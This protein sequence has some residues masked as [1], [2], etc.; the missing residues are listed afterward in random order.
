MGQF[1]KGTIDSATGQTYGNIEVIVVDDGSTDDTAQI[2][3]ESARLDDRVTVIKIGE[4]KG[5]VQARKHGA[6][7]ATGDFV[8]FLDGDDELEPG[9]CETIADAL[10]DGLPDVLQFNIEVI[11][12]CE[13]AQIN[14]K[15]IEAWLR[16]YSE[17]DVV[18]DNLV[19]VCFFEKLFSYNLAGKAFRAGILKEAFSQT[20]EKHIVMAE[21]AYLQFIILHHARSYRGIQ[22]TLYKYYRGRGVTGSAQM[23]VDEFNT[24]CTQSVAIQSIRDFLDGSGL[25]SV[26]A[27]SYN[28]IKEKLLIA[29]INRWR[30]L[31]ATD[32]PA[33]F[34]AMVGSWGREDVSLALDK[35]YD[36]ETAYTEMHQ[37]GFWRY[38]QEKGFRYWAKLY[39]SRPVQAALKL[40]RLFTS[41]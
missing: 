9:A 12:L 13:L 6:I 18:S 21:D 22:K 5:L 2:A 33:G 31:E 20:N 36:G 10:K 1:L 17:K 32:R 23:S 15:E 39:D 41:S 24:Y 38:Y 3:E 19:G 34:D 26:Y 35:V 16:P 7:R 30:M 4:N 40:R 27:A 37:T 8:I 29:C 11:N 25:F 28:A 14:L